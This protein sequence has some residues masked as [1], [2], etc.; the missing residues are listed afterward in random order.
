MQR[1]HRWAGLDS[2]QR[3]AFACQVYS[4][5]PLTTRPPTHAFCISSQRH[6]REMF[7]ILVARIEARAPR[8][9]PSL[10]SYALGHH[11]GSMYFP[12]A[13]GSAVRPSACRIVSSVCM[14][15]RSRQ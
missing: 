14:P 13:A 1:P 6:T 7:A 8:A 15:G 5:V 12:T 2:N 10:R 9:G 3:N 4:L 11:C